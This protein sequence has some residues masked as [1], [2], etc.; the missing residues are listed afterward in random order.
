MIS[1]TSKITDQYKRNWDVAYRRNQAVFRHIIRRR[2]SQIW[3][4][5]IACFCA[6]WTLA[7]MQGDRCD[8]VTKK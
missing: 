1:L 6:E 2:R 8:S 4:E 7:E 5:N 3:K